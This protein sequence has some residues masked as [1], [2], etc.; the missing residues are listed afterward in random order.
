MGPQRSLKPL[1]VRVAA[2][3]SFQNAL[4]SQGQQSHGYHVRLACHAFAARAA[5]PASTR[6]CGGSD[7]AHR[8]ATDGRV[9][10]LRPVGGRRLV[11]PAPELVRSAEP[12]GVCVP[13]L[14]VFPFSV[15]Q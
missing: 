13:M 12:R 6:T 7:V 4:Q 11:V 8:A 14:D 5:D 2:S 15:F 10:C 9:A 1:G 3:F